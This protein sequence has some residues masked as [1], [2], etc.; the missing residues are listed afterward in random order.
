MADLT[1]RGG[2]FSDQGLRPNNEDRFVADL[3]RHAFL[4][5][6]GMGG[7]DRGEIAS[8]MAAEIIPQVVQDRL[9]ASDDATQAVQQAL[10]AA[11]HAIIDAARTQPEGRRM[12]TTA[13]LAVERAGR[14]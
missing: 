9:A 8:G 4:V 13:V 1:L 14:V 6:D 2:S 10:A 7:Q 3:D 5:A 11:N 12:G